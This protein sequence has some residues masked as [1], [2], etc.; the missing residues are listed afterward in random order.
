[1]KT[2]TRRVIIAMVLTPLIVGTVGACGGAVAGGPSA[3]GYFFVGTTGFATVFGLIYGLPLHLV[4]KRL[5]RT[6]LVPYL[7]GALPAGLIIHFL[8]E[9]YVGL[10]IAFDQVSGGI[11]SPVSLILACM[12]TAAIAWA[13]ARPDRAE[14]G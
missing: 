7:V 5:G 8:N 3:A 12:A 6:G 4:L 13:I 10:Q 14:P 2:S 11:V 9:E 1:V